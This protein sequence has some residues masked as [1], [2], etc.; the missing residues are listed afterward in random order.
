M[1]TIQ[2]AILTLS[3][4]GARGQRED[5]SGPALTAWLEQHASTVAR[6]HL[7]PD[8]PDA[9]A[10]LLA[11]WADEN[12]FHLILTTGG[13]GVSPRDRTPEATS[14]ILDVVVPGIGEVM[15]AAS[16]KITPLAMLSRAVAGVRKRTLILNL[17]GSPKAA[18]ECIEAVWP[19][20]PHA[21]EKIQGGTRDCAS[22][23]S[24]ALPTSP[25]DQ[26]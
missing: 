26:S 25:A 3:D 15:R 17:P 1:T 20:I 13:T 2:A 22:T 18:V 16:M 10:D 24:A 4:K 5:R 12:C 9:I 14:R 6:T 7:L 21:I 8:E 23:A 11:D 19:A